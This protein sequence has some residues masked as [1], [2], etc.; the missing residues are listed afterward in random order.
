LRERERSAYAPLLTA[1]ATECKETFRDALPSKKSCAGKHPRRTTG[2]PHHGP[3]ISKVERR[4]G[5]R[6]G[7]GTGR[8]VRRGRNRRAGRHK[9]QN[10]EEEW[11]RQR[12]H[13]PVGPCQGGLKVPQ[14]V[15]G[16]LVVGA[17]PPLG[18][19]WMD[20]EVYGPTTTIQGTGRQCGTTI[21]PAVPLVSL[22]LPPSLSPSLP[23]SLPP[24]LPTSALPAREEPRA[25]A[26]LLFAS[27]HLLSA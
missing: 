22:P 15:H 6:G 9:C 21:P 23:P 27:P 26:V 17:L 18:P 12:F 10:S 20:I 4:R 5:E 13:A 8:G 24:P 11:G 3:K 14:V 25:V 1:E 19:A 7:G 2:C 16:A